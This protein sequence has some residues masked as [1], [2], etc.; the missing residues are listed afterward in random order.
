MVWCAH[1]SIPPHP[2]CPELLPPPLVV[3]P[4]VARR[5]ALMLASAH[6]CTAARATSNALRACRTGR[7]HRGAG[8]TP[9]PFLS[10]A[11]CWARWRVACPP[12]RLRHLRRIGGRGGICSRPP[13]AMHSVRLASTCSALAMHG[14]WCAPAACNSGV[15]TCTMAAQSPCLPLPRAR[16]AAPRTGRPHAATAP[17][18]LD[19]TC[20]HGRRHRA[21]FAATPCV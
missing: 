1:A 14:Q 18:L 15:P 20:V 16:A 7:Q 2:C 17:M 11:T 4:A 10:V 8:Q 21:A 19:T 13:C 6:A 12:S 5:T 9:P 3:Q